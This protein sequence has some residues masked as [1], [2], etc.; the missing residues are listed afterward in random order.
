[1]TKIRTQGVIALA[2]TV[3]VLAMVILA[4][5]PPAA[6]VANEASGDTHSIDILGIT[7]NARNL[8]EEQF[9]AH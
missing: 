2:S 8:P 6:I 1:M 9:P 4:L 7:K 3:A 5:S